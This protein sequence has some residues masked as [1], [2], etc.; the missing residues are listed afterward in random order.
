MSIEELRHTA[1]ESGLEH[2]YYLHSHGPRLHVS[3][4]D[5]RLV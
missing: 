1:P 4:G 2:R 5:H 3:G